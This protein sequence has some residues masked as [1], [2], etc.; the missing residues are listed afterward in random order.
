MPISPLS[1]SRRNGGIENKWIES[2]CGWTP[3]DGYEVTGW[4]QGTFVRG[5]KVMWDD[6]ILGNSNGQPIK[7]LEALP[8]L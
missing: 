4:P 8:A 7:F 1:I 3:Y 5:R 2:K 6:Q